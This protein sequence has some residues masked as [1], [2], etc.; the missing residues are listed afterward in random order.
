MSRGGGTV[1]HP[2]FAPGETQQRGLVDAEFDGD[3]GD[4]VFGVPVTVA[5]GRKKPG[6]DRKLA[7]LRARQRHAVKDYIPA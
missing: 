5:A 1:T 2:A 6:T 3:V 7:G 4:A